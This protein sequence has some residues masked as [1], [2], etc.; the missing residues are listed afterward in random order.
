M[1][2]QANH[3]PF[4]I[5]HI[6]VKDKNGLPLLPK[7]KLTVGQRAVDKLTHFCGS[8]KFIILILLYIILWISLNLF[9]WNLRWD[10]WPFIILNLT[11]SS[12]AALQAPVILMSQNRTAERDRL[13]QRY[14]Y[15]VDRKTGRDTQKILHELQVIKEEMAKHVKES[16]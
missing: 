2:K 13:N 14:D 12:L 7:E 3:I 15:L 11:L 6:E 4:T 9:A 10:P 1:K 8:W 5:K 16:N